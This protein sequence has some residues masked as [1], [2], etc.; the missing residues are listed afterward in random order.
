[1]EAREIKP[2]GKSLFYHVLA[3]VAVYPARTIEIS[4]TRIHDPLPSSGLC[5]PTGKSGLPLRIDLITY[6]F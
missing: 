1:M 2:T 5:G 3:Q 4:L 6:P